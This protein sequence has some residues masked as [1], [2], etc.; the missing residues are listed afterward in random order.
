MRRALDASAIIAWLR[1]EEGADAVDRIIFSSEHR[2]V[3]AHSFNLME[4]YK[5]FLAPDVPGT[6]EEALATLLEAGIEVREDMDLELCLKALEV[7]TKH[8]MSW[9]DAIG[10]ALSIRL[11]ADFVSADRAELEA[12]HNDHTALVT[13]IR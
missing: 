4:V 6:P 13:F 2:P 3:Y 5:H 12:A 1:D 10:I 11:M 8:P 7:R 9:P